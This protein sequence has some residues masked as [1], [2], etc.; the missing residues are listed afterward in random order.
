MLEYYENQYPITFQ[1]CYS[2][3]TEAPVQL[4]ERF[5]NRARQTVDLIPDNQVTQ[6]NNNY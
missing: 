1:T 4:S 6:V 2:R 5:F 3:E